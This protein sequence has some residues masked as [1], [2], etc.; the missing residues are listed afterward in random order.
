MNFIYLI[1]ETKLLNS[2]VKAC[3]EASMKY[4]HCGAWH[5]VH[6]KYSSFLFAVRKGTRNEYPQL[7]PSHDTLNLTSEPL[8][9]GANSTK[10]V[11]YVG[12]YR[13]KDGNIFF[14]QWNNNSSAYS[15]NLRSSVRIQ[16]LWNAKIAAV[17]EDLKIYSKIWNN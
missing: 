8:L 4:I 14:H 15:W 12:C 16:G 7:H 6:G 2:S 13:K 9:N 17:H 11:G 1:Y 3:Y 5:I 10:A